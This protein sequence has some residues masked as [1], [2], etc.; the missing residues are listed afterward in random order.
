[1]SI[2]RGVDKGRG[3][4]VIRRG[5]AH[6][7]AKEDAKEPNALASQYEVSVAPEVLKRDAG[8]LANTITA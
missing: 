1:M 4:N 8:F 5:H 7:R 6:P 3:E 2:E